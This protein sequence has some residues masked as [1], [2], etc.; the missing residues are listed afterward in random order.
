MIELDPL[1]VTETYN[2]WKLAAEQPW[3]SYKLNEIKYFVDG[4]M[5]I[6]GTSILCINPCVRSIY[7]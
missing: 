6:Y 2:F 3:E 5:L 1:S 7:I 4:N